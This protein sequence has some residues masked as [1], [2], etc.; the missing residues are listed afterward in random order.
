MPDRP[1]TQ[2]YTIRSPEMARL[3]T[4]CWICSVPSKMSWIFDRPLE[5]LTGP[6]F[7]CPELCE[8][9]HFCASPGV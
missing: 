5:A 7:S 4:S 1:S 8:L 2:I 6:G 9:T 3:M